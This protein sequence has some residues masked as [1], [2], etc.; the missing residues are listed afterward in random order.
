MDT[1]LNNV[2]RCK[3]KLDFFQGWAL[4][5]GSGTENPAVCYRTAR[6]HRRPQVVLRTAYRE[7]QKTWI[8]SA[9]PYR[10]NALLRYRTVT[11]DTVQ[12]TIL[13]Q[14]IK[15]LVTTMDRKRIPIARILSFTFIRMDQDPLRHMHCDRRG[16]WL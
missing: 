5:S 8:S 6:Y 13:R 1:N 2:V 14:K 3:C 11:C 9:V 4:A 7:Q 12:L 16:S 15:R 10:H